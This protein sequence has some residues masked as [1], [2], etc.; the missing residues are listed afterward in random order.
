MVK[1]KK[2]NGEGSSS[3]LLPLQGQNPILKEET[4]VCYLMCALH[5]LHF[6]EALL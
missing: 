4:S 6:L 1:H 3:K 2:E 5:S